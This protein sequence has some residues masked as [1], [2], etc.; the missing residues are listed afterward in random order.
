VEDEMALVN[1]SR[2]TPAQ[3]ADGAY[4]VRGWE[5]R[6]ELD[7]EKV[8]KVDDMLVDDHDY[9][10]YL[11][12]DLGIF[13][14]HVLVPLSEAHAD[15]SAQVVW[16]DQLDRE[17]LRHLPDY[18][19]DLESLSPEYEERLLEEYRVLARDGHG[20]PQEERA[21][22]RLARLGDLD[23]FRVAKG[24]TD[25]RGWKLVAGDGQ[26]LGEVK[27]L[28]VDTAAMTTRYL[29]AEV[30]EKKLE[31][32][33]LGRHVLVPS[34]RVRLDRGEK[35]AVVDGLFSRD[36]ERYPIYQGLPLET[37][38]ERAIHQAFTSARGSESRTGDAAATRFFGVRERAMGATATPPV[39]SR[40]RPGEL[41]RPEVEPIAVERAETDV[42]PAAAER[43]DPEASDETVIRNSE[44][45][46]IRISGDDIIIEKHP[47]G[48][49]DDG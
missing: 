47:R 4:D 21:P 39:R 6:T 7:G 30:D 46:R 17:R 38:A 40:G 33:R 1:L 5:V 13:R 41:D 43:G 28:I 26:V 32:E 2:R 29:V 49:R 9:P 25:P 8:G 31:L 35:H 44:N 42:E 23:D 14:K 48:S 15:P 37:S 10:R 20:E 45:V 27:E 36:V 18:D 16:I 19:H 22:S 3:L 11:D 34:E 12:V 24:V